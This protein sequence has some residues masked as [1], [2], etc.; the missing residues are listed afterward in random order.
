MKSKN[1]WKYGFNWGSIIGGA[2]FVYHIIGF[3]L[4]IEANFLWGLLG[5]FIIVFGM[6]WSMVN[7]KKNVLK[8]NLK[9][10][11]F[12]ALGTIMSLFI[13]IF[14]LFF[15]FLYVAKLN[16][17]YLDNFLLQYQDVLD[18]AGSEVDIVNDPLFMKT[19]RI[20]F[21]PSI[22]IFD[23]IGNLFYVLLFSFLLSRQGI[24]MSNVQNRPDANDY[25]PYQDVKK[26]EEKD[27]EQDEDEREN[28]DIEEIGA[29]ES[30]KGKTKEDDKEEKE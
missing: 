28:D 19:I 14:F 30:G 4:K 5:T 20:F 10:G 12:F 29:I 24:G 8:E 7:Y 1:I 3:F 27:V 13:S 26:E 21:F 9:F 6:G 23:F 25:V 22:Y 17:T 2:F 16:T 15:M 11:K 18:S